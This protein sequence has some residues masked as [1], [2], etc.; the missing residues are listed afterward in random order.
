MGRGRP[1]RSDACG[2]LC[3]MPGAAAC[4]CA[5]GSRLISCEAD[6]TIKLWKQDENA[7]PASA[8][9]LPYKPPKDIRRF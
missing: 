3:G 5:A 2:H 8:P 1:L 9:G 6:K 4:C 7:T